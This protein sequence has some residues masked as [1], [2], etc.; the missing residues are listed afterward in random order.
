MAAGREVLADPSRR[1]VVHCHMG[2]NRAPSM[3]FAI[4]LA[5]GWEPVAE[6]DAIRAARPIAKVLYADDTIRWWLR[7]QGAS[8]AEIVEG[9][10]TVAQWHA[11]NPLDEAFAIHRIRI[12]G[13]T[14]EGN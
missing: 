13:R 10:E 3:A 5:D 7:R 11:D 12:G 14:T 2:I 9:V 1:A 4:L 6:L 8:S